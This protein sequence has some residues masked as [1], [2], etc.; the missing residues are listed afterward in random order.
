MNLLFAGVFDGFPG[1]ISLGLF[2][3]LIIFAFALLIVALKGYSLWHA[4]KRNEK[5]WFVAILILNTIGILE[6]IYLIFIVKKWPKIY[7]GKKINSNNSIDTSTPT[8]TPSNTV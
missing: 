7:N 6:L 1:M 3:M 2:G 8:S 4:A 5:W